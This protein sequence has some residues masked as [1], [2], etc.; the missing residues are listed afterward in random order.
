MITIVLLVL[1]GA[2]IY[3][4]NEVMHGDLGL[5]DTVA[6][7]LIIILCVM[8]VPLLFWDRIHGLK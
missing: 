5:V 8:A 4:L 7:V 6:A 1:G 2:L 3:T